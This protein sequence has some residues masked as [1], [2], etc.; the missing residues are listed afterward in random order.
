MENQ[1]NNNYDAKAN[2][3]CLWDLINENKPSKSNEKM[4]F[5]KIPP[6]T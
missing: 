1:T 2:I 5:M 6:I 4:E 3:N